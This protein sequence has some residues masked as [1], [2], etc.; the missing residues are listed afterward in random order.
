M[1]L[2]GSRWSSTTVREVERLDRRATVDELWTL[3]LVLGASL[4]ELLDP[5]T[6]GGGPSYMSAWVRGLVQVS[7]IGGLDTGEL[8]LHVA[9]APGVDWKEAL[10][11]TI[12]R[13]SSEEE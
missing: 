1:R 4:H 10:A 11:A 8:Q 3:G 7:I 9:P 6:V 2:A 5:S 12:E 13:P